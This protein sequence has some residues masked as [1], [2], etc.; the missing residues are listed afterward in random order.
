MAFTTAPSLTETSITINL[1][2]YERLVVDG[3]AAR[4]ALDQ[5]RQDVDDITTRMS[6]RAPSEA[7]RW[8]DVLELMEA[9]EEAQRMVQHHVST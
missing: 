7:H 6:A 3:Y 5:L 1:S 8:G 2:H 9:C 4:K